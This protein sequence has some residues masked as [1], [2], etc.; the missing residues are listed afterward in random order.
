MAD[1]SGTFTTGSSIVAKA[2]SGYDTN[3]D[4]F[5]GSAMVR[6]EGQICAAARYD[7]KTNI[8]D[9]GSDTKGLLDDVC[10][11]LVANE[12]IAFNMTGYPTRI[13]AEDMIN[14]NR[15]TFLRGI[16]MLKDNKVSD[17]MRG[18]TS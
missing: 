6:A 15:D 8:A 2:G 11:S 9:I 3:F 4:G 14:I 12:A 5:L 17:F 13:V 10:S 16:R 7:F 1:I 18:K